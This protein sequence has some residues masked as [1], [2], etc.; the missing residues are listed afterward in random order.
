MR[1]RKLLCHPTC[2]L[3]CKYREK[4]A[5]SAAYV[6][7]VTH[8]RFRGLPKI[9]NKNKH[10]S[11]AVAPGNPCF[12]LWVREIFR[13]EFRFCSNGLSELARFLLRAGALYP[14]ARVEI[15]K[16]NL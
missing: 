5:I 6:T 14:C 8:G 7:P 11:P 3:S 2:L 13:R 16:K 4:A 15:K 1:E 12:L 10:L 9:L